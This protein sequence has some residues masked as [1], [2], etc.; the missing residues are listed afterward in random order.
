MEGSQGH[1]CPSQKHSKQTTDK[2][3]EST[4][5]YNYIKVTIIIII[6]YNIYYIIIV[7]IIYSI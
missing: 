4:D 1:S 5:V 2:K 6:I 3:T 7:T